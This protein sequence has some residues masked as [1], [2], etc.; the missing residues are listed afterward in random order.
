MLPQEPKKDDPPLR[1]FRTWVGLSN[2]IVNLARLVLDVVIK[3]ISV[4]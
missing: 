4:P 1:D 2:L 3:L